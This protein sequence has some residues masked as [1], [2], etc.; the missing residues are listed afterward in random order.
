MA[1]EVIQRDM[2][3]AEWVDRLPA[4]HSARDQ[5]ALLRKAAES[6]VAEELGKPIEDPYPPVTED[7]VKPSWG[8]GALSELAREIHGV[9]VAIGWDV[10][11]FDTWASPDKMARCLLLVVEEVI[12][13]YRE[14][15]LYT[16]PDEDRMVGEIADIII[17]ALSLSHGLGLDIDSAVR[18]KVKRNR[19]EGRRKRAERTV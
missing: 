9:N 16:V 15:R 2:T 19:E 5:F 7:E 12:E 14:I 18:R 11:D 17:R 1:G 8:L 10:A 6:V 4:G 3:L 13:T